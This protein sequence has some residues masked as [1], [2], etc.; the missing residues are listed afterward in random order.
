LF[1][2][3]AALVVLTGTVPQGCG[4]TFYAR[5]I[6]A[7]HRRGVRVLVDAQGELLANALKAGPFLVR[8]NRAELS[9]V[10]SHRGAEWL[11]VSNGAGRITVAGHAGRWSVK[12]PRVKAVNPVGS[13]DAMLAGM[14]CA[15][16]RGEPVTDVVRLGVA[17]G[18]AN[19]LTPLPGMVRRA[20]V[21]KLLRRMK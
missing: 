2:W 19:A 8:V 1:A 3:R 5:L 10:K 11:V 17:C 15:L 9:A 4:V 14:A 21:Q 18:A 13:G 16:W 12:P 7:A 6:N 20:D